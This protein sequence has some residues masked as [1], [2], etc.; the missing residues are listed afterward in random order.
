MRRARLRCEKRRDPDRSRDEQPRGQRCRKA[1]RASLDDAAHQARERGER[2]DL[3]GDVD[4]LHGARRGGEL[5][6]EYQDRHAHGDVDGEDEAPMD[7]DEKASEKRAR[8]RG[9]RSADAPHGEREPAVLLGSVGFVGERHG[10]RQDEG[11]GRAHDRTAEYEHADG[12]GKRADGGAQGEPGRSEDEG[13]FRPE[14]VREVAGEQQ[15]GGERQRV[16]VD[17]PL[18]RR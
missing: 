7:G 10:A 16:A 3:A 12:A 6:A 9:G 11:G 14:A 2:E 1:H 8:R 4:R 15:Q 13:A 18:L 17:D 5:A